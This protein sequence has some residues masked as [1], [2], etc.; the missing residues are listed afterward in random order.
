[1]T[2]RPDDQARA[3]FE[4]LFRETRSDLLAYALRRAPTAEDAADVVAGTYLIAWRRLERV[5]SGDDARLWLFGVARNLLLKGAGRRRSGDRLVERLA[6]ELRASALPHPPVEDER[7]EP[8]AAAL[9]SLS[10]SDREILTLSSWEGL[11]PRQ[12]AAV[13][14]MSANAVRV[15]LHRARKRLLREL[16]SPRPGARRTERVALERD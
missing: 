7:L 3:A 6:R 13:T 4:R 2:R 1:V 12:I 14:G 5:P 11:T 8:L 10:G 9:A 16:G 15:R